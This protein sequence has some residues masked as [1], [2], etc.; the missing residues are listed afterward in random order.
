MSHSIARHI[1]FKASEPKGDKNAKDELK[2]KDQ[3]KKARKLQEKRQAQQGGRKRPREEDPH[4]GEM[5]PSK[6]FK[7]AAY[8][9]SKVIKKR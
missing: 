4:R 5:R 9:R 7:G 2:S 8:S 3:I 6:K 1:R